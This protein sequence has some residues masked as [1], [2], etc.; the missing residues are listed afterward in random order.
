M[1]TFDKKNI[2]ENPRVSLRH[3]LKIF[4]KD[5]FGEKA[6]N[7]IKKECCEK[8]KEKNGGERIREYRIDDSMSVSAASKHSRN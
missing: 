8:R 6:A 5:S 3:F 2:E 4:E 1:A 7:A